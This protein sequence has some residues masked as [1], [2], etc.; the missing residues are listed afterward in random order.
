MALDE[1]VWRR[2]EC[3]GLI[4][5]E[6]E[7]GGFWVQGE[8]TLSS[9]NG[10]EHIGY[11]EAAPEGVATRDLLASLERVVGPVAPVATLWRHWGMDPY[12]LGYVSHWAPGDL[13]A[14][15]PLHATHEPP[16]YVAGSDQWAVRLHGGC[17]RHRPGSGAGGV[18]G[19]EPIPL[20]PAASGL[21]RRS[22]GSATPGRR[23]PVPSA[24]ARARRR[25]RGA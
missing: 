14:V 11:L 22:A 18:M 9:L 8:N 19:G 15:G 25:R 21:I 12:T 5:S 17:G 10:P 1:P 7:T 2:V 6:H 20:Y 13:T 23:R 16:F 3:N 4:E 24:A